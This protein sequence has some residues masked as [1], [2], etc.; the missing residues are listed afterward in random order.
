MFVYSELEGV[1]IVKFMA[2]VVHVVVPE[3]AVYAAAS[4]LMDDMML[5]GMLLLSC[6]MEDVA[7]GVTA[8]ED[9]PAAPQSVLA[10]A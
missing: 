5:S 3:Y 2:L 9:W 1:G 4:L 8:M 10:N 6:G 7:I